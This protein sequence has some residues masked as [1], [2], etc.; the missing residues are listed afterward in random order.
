VPSPE[1]QELAFAGGLAVLAGTE[2]H[3]AHSL[4]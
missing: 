2:T 1:M 4:L 3:H